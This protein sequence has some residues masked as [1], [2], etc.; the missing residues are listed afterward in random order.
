[1][2]PL[3]PL[4]PFSYT[5]AVNEIWQQGQKINKRAVSSASLEHVLV[6]GD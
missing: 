6:S 4:F 3:N 2:I 5:L 1:V